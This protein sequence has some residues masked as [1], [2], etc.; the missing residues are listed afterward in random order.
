MLS[1]MTLL[2][3]PVAE[4]PASEEL[5]RKLAYKTFD[6][7]GIYAGIAYGRN[8][9]YVSSFKDWMIEA[10]VIDVV[11]VTVLVLFTLTY[12]RRTSGIK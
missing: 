12:C 9:A 10:G 1:S 5:V 2:F 11:K 4:S 7:T 3:D 8:F 6:D